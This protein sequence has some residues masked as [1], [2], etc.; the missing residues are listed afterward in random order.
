VASGDRR[1]GVCST[2]RHGSNCA[3]SKDTGGDVIQCEGF[4]PCEPGPCPGKGSGL[5]PSK[6][7]ESRSSEGDGNGLARYK[8]LCANCENRKACKFPKPEWGVWHCG[9]YR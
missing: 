2:C 4:E 6:E 5:L 9:E 1:T 8:G 3:Y 7:E